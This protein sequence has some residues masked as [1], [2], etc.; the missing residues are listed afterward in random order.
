MQVRVYTTKMA[1]DRLEALKQVEN[2]GFYVYSKSEWQVR[3]K[4][5]DYSM[6]YVLK[7]ENWQ[8][9]N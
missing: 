9:R 7:G 3:K 2:G 1:E 6:V 8:R 4:F 5:R